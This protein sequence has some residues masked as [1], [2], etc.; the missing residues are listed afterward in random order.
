MS[1]QQ[2]TEQKRAARAWA[3]ISAAKGED[4]EGRYGA[5]A[6]KLPALVLTNG[7]GQALAFLRAKNKPQHKALYKH[8]STW[9]TAQTYAIEGDDQLLERLIG[10]VPGCESSSDVYRRATTETL[11]FINWLKRFAEAELKIE[12]GED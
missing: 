7:L 5:E 8:I 2:T 3:D 9:V 1:L 6:K 12:E 10:A 11:A 4:Y